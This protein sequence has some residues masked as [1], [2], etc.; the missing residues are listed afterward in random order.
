MTSRRPHS[1]RDAR[2]TDG[3]ITQARQAEAGKTQSNPP[4]RSACDLRCI[5]ESVPKSADLSRSLCLIP[6]LKFTCSSVCPHSR[7]VSLQ[8]FSIVPPPFLFFLGEDFVEGELGHIH[9]PRV[10]R[11]DGRGSRAPDAPRSIRGLHSPRPVMRWA[12][13]VIRASHMRL[14]LSLLLACFFIRLC[15]CS[16]RLWLIL[17][18]FVLRPLHRAPWLG[19]SCAVSPHSVTYVCG[20]EL[21]NCMICEVGSLFL[22]RM[23]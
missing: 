6:I 7:F 18:C 21:P 12:P 1:P 17:V 10:S 16:G 20:I 2:W 22:L 14:S 4:P 19:S 8:V 9:E 5:L 3:Y 11:F 13:W 15:E 23:L